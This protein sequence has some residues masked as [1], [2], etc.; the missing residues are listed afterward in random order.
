MTL[1]HFG[2][3]EQLD[4]HGGGRRHGGTTISCMALVGRRQDGGVDPT[5]LEPRLHRKR[6]GV[7]TERTNMLPLDSCVRVTSSHG[8]GAGSRLPISSG[9]AGELEGYEEDLHICIL[10]PIIWI[11]ITYR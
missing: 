8:G 6:G 5:S 7:R 3:V 10:S 11:C 9:D 1:V 2:Q 4:Q